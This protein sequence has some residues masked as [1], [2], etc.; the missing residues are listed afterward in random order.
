MSALLS[1]DLI[2]T[3]RR[4][5]ELKL[6]PLSAADRERAIEIAQEILYALGGL[7]GS[8]EEEVELCLGGIECTTREKKLKTALERLALSNST[9]E[10]PTELAPVE[11]RRMVFEEAARARAEMREKF[12]RKLVLSQVG[13]RVGAT[14]EELERALFSD[15][16]GA[17]ELRAA[18]ALSAEALVA[19][20]EEAQLLGVFLRAVRVRARLRLEN[21]AEVRKLFWKLKFRELL[22]RLEERG[23]GEYELQ[24]EGPSSLL[25]SSTR[26]GL[27]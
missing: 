26:Y 8:T 4:G 9:F 23:P 24:L 7:L 27:R 18:P 16:K 10:A 13:E 6:A 22:F 1:P 17:A 21:P 14:R 25:V 3:R 20:Y 5:D 12:D 15:L 2:A 19:M 11:L